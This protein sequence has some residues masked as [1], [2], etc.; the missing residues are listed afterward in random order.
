MEEITKI[1]NDW[2]PIELFPMAPKDE[3]IDEIRSIYSYIQSSQEIGV[4]SLAEA[5]NNIFIHNFGDDTYHGDIN[6]CLSVASR[7][8]NEM[9]VSK[10]QEMHWNQAQST[11]SRKH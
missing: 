9:N 2:D 3:Y 8:L 6:Q 7:I 5:I 11:N 4:H 10:R 1:I